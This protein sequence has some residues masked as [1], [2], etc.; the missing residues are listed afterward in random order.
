MG[1]QRRRVRPVAGAWLPPAKA[2]AWLA[3]SKD[4]LSEI[5]R[6][7]KRSPAP[8]GLPAA[9]GPPPDFRDRHPWSAAAM[10]PPCARQATLAADRGA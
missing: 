9:F 6:R 4:L 3:H 8:L 10:L 2:Q 7:L 1:L 5:R